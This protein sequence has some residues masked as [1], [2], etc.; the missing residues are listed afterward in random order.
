MLYGDYYIHGMNEV[1]S[2]LEAHK[3]ESNF[4]FLHFFDTHSHHRRFG[5]LTNALL[6]P[7][8][9]NGRRSLRNSDQ[10]SLLHYMDNERKARL[11]EIDL[12]LSA[13]FSYIRRQPW[14]DNAM[15]ILTADHGIS[16]NES[17]TM[18]LSY[19]HVHIPLMV[20]GP[21]IQ[22]GSEYSLIEG[23]V[24]LMPSMLYF[25]GAD[26]PKDIDGRVWPFLGGI[27]RKE[28]FSESLY[29]KKYEAAL[30]AASR[31]LYFK[32]AYD[33]AASKI[34]FD[35]DRSLNIYKRVDDAGE[36]K[37]EEENLAHA[38]DSDEL[39]KKFLSYHA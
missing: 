17:D 4:A 20:L 12:A 23:S 6:E 3:D 31:L 33:Y 5:Y 27:P 18:R 38:A 25:A 13:F 21:D 26:V 19:S 8:R 15:I 10:K 34:R 35:K 7:F 30:R 29:F 9:Y 32:C 37:L 39:Y 28:A 2:H 1:I 11:Y 24:D 14:F 22:K 16:D 36:E